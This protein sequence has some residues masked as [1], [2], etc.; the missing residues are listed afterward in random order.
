MHGGSYIYVNSEL[1]CD[2]IVDLVALSVE[3]VCEISATNVIDY[4]MAVVCIYRSNQT[5]F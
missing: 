2:E 4:N 3:Q 1:K 5:F